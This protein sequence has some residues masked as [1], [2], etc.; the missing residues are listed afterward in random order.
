MVPH[1]WR[2]GFP[3]LC[4]IAQ[5]LLSLHRGK[6]GV[7]YTANTRGS[8]ILLICSR[9][10]TQPSPMPCLRWSS[11]FLEIKLDEG[12]PAGSVARYLW[13]GAEA[14]VVRLE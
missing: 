6:G 1:Q 2:Y 11:L 10:R 13:L 3:P 12:I 7:E 14:V 8:F 4:R 5:R 9:L